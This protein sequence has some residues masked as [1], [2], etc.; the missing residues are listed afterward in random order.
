MGRDVV[1]LEGWSGRRLLSR[2][3]NDKAKIWEKGVP[4][5]RTLQCPGHLM[6]MCWA[7]WRHSK[8]S[9]E[10]EAELKPGRDMGKGT[11]QAGRGQIVQGLLGF[12]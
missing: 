6:G 12:D 5:S 3:L 8:E 10:A 1:L 11:G 4:G 9:S 7:C 2:D